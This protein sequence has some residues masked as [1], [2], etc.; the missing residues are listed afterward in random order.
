MTVYADI[1]YYTGTYRE[2]AAPLIPY[3]LYGIYARKA[4][5]DID[6]YTFGN[7]GDNIPEAVQ[8]CCCELAEALYNIDSSAAPGGVSSEK[9]GDVT[10]NY[11]SGELRRQNLPKTIKSIIYSWLA[12]TGL[13]HRGGDLC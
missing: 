3:E 8:L 12:D 13:L 7:I 11:E 2:D 6:Q 5:A 10:V 1:D 9:V 4:S